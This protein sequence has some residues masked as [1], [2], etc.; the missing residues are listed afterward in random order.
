[1]NLLLKFAVLTSIINEGVFN[2]FTKY[3][4]VGGFSSKYKI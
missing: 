4:W 2:K 1:M 3:T